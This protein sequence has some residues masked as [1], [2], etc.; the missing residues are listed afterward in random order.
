MG[1][2]TEIII[3]PY[4]LPVEVTI[5]DE[6]ED[7]YFCSFYDQFNNQRVFRRWYNKKDIKF[8]NQEDK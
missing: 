6:T 2:K 5:D 8:V 7:Q 4:G 3:G 1:K